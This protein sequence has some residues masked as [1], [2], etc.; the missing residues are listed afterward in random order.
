MRTMRQE[1]H[2]NILGKK[3]GSKR[4]PERTMRRWTGS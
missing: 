1:K 2:T 3:P 4:P